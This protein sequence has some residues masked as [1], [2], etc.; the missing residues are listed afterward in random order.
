MGEVRG[1]RQTL[2]MQYFL[3]AASKLA[4]L[5]IDLHSCLGGR[6]LGQCREALRRLAPLPLACSS[7]E[8]GV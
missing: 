8:G 3:L 4:G 2:L 1:P 7:C 5:Q 6:V